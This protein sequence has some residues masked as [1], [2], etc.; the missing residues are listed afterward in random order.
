MIRPVTTAMVALGLVLAGTPALSGG[1]Y[2]GCEETVAARLAELG[3]APADVS[4]ITNVPE[5]GGGSRTSRGAVIG[6]KAW[7]SLESC[8]G[9]V[10]IHM[11][12]RC[13]IKQTWT[14]G[15]C[16]VPGLKHY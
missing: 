2:D 16:Q 6:V 15:E 8:K 10:V 4:G 7:V 12:T 3:I 5:H 9:S 1:R 14:R 13:R 11:N